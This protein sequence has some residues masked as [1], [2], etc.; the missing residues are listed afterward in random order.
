MT[1]FLPRSLMGQMMLLMAVALLVAQLA[2]LAF[3]LNE[4]Q[5]LNLA[6]NEGPA[7]VRYAEVAQHVT[8]MPPEARDRFIAARPRVAQ[9]YFVGSDSPIRLQGLARNA[10][11]ERRLERLLAEAAVPIRN[12]EVATR[13]ESPPIG[14]R[15]HHAHDRRTVYISGAMPDGRRLNAIMPIPPRDPWLIHRLLLATTILFL[16]VLGVVWWTARRLSRPLRALTAAAE[17]FDGRGDVPPVQPRGPADVRLAVEAFNAMNRRTAGMLDEKDR[18]LG[19]IGHDLRT[20]LASLRI[21]AENMGPPEERE[22]LVATVEEMAA[23]LEDIL[24]LARTGRAREPVRPVDVAALAD[25]LTEEYRALGRAVTFRES[26]RAVLEVQPNLLRRA[27]RNLIDNGVVHAGS[28]E[29]SVAETGN[30]VEIRIS[31]SGPGIPPDRI[32]DLLEPFQRLEASRNRESGGG[33]LGLPIALAVAQAHGG[34]LVLDR[35]PGGGLSTRLILP[36]PQAP[37]SGREGGARG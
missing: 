30:A 2:N 16:L 31:D 34:R 26:P 4:Q 6:Q 32:A 27:L 11:L 10:E 21:R 19:A 1:R 33:G 28:A 9:A 35:R 37:G 3:I 7:L 22:R 17:G 13:I 23:A 15:F 8:R 24:T 5:K 14:P 18:M 29:V 25:A 20:P 36:R 12:V